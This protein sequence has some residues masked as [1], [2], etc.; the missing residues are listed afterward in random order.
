MSNSWLNEFKLIEFFFPD[1]VGFHTM[2]ASRR[3]VGVS[4]FINKKYL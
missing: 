3:G 2:R 4:V 1:F